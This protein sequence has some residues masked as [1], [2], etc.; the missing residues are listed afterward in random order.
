CSELFVISQSSASTI[1]TYYN[2]ENYIGPVDPNLVQNITSNLEVSENSSPQLQYTD[3][4]ISKVSMVNDN[5]IPNKTKFQPSNANFMLLYEKL[6]DAI[7][8][9]NCKTQ[10]AIMCYCLFGKALIQRRNEIASKK[11]IDLESNI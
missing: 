8:L 2:K 3:S 11:Q 1:E 7:I 10:E 6:C 9:A 5:V 4:I